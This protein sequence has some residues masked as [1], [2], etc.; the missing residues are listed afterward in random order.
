MLSEAQK[1]SLYDMVASELPKKEWANATF[2]T[3]SYYMGSDLDVLYFEDTYM[4]DASG[5]LA[6][7]GI[8]HRY[9]YRWNSFDDAENYAAKGIIP[10]RLEIQTK[11]YG[12]GA[13]V[14]DAEGYKKALKNRYEIKND[15][16]L[17]P[18]T[19]YLLRRENQ[20]MLLRWFGNPLLGNRLSPVTLAMDAARGRGLANFRYSD[21]RPSVRLVVKRTRF[22]I[23]KATPFGYGDNPDN[24]FLITI[25]EASVY[26]PGAPDKAVGTFSEIEI[27]F[28]R[29]T[30]FKLF[31]SVYKAGNADNRAV[32]ASFETDQKTVKGLISEKLTEL[33]FPPE[34]GKEMQTK[35]SKALRA[36]EVRK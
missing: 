28:E 17:N 18:V 15:F 12:T 32:L 23:N 11:A 7:S 31:D 13:S 36:S 2:V 10:Q 16:R 5:S 27:D 30:F 33:G 25:D 9:R 35:Y 26:L 22:H 4:D 1:K 24:V 19:E 34:S 8:S 21:L 29:N 20:D 3:G 6:K 14:A